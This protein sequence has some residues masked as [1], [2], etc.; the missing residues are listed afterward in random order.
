M[1]TCEIFNLNFRICQ[2]RFEI[3]M[4]VRCWIDFSRFFIRFNSF[5]WIN[6]CVIIVRC[7]FIIEII[8]IWL[9]KCIDQC[10]CRIIFLRSYSKKDFKKIE[11]LFSN[12]YVL[13]KW[14]CIVERFQREYRRLTAESLCNRI[15]RVFVGPR[16]TAEGNLEIK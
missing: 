9:D 13:S 8:V 3:G 14:S 10:C 11:F 2:T 15:V 1:C 6:Q 12:K 16:L 5:L 7:D 4:F